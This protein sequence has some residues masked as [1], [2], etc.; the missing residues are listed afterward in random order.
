MD[1]GDGTENILGGRE[2][3][4]VCNPSA[5]ERMR[6]IREVEDVLANAPVDIIGIS[7]GFDNHLDDWGGLLETDD[8]RTI[9]ALV[10]NAARSNRGGCFALLEGGYNHDVLGKNVA[11]LLEGLAQ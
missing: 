2:W 6:Y 4:T 11:A 5:H 10:N 3:V 9:G 8:Y 7:A 1:L